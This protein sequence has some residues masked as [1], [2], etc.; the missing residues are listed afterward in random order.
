MDLLDVLLLVPTPPPEAYLLN[1]ASRQTYGPQA[2]KILSAAYKLE[3][4]V[5]RDLGF[6]ES[7]YPPT[8]IAHRSLTAVALATNLDRAGLRWAVVDPGMRS[9]HYWRGELQRYQAQRPSGIAISTTY[10]MSPEWLDE[11]ITACRE[12]SPQAR[13]VVGGY[14]YGTASREFLS[15]NA[16]LICVGEG[17]FRLP[18]V[19]KAIRDEQ[20]F[21]SIPG[22]YIRTANG[23]LKFTGPAEPLKLQTLTPPDWMLSKQ[24]Q[25]PIDPETDEISVCLETQRAACSNASSA[26]SAPSRLQTRLTSPVQS[27]RYSEQ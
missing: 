23:D 14:M 27:M 7:L 21:E 4:F 26:P 20:P 2:L 12:I 15:L 10:F 9:L 11:L 18:L 24:I 22:V 19:A 3:T 1:P 8:A 6:N 5:G 16:D 17:E 13:I 25:P